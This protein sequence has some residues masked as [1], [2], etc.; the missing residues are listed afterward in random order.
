MCA[1]I[2]MARTKK[3]HNINTEDAEDTFLDYFPD[4]PIRFNIIQRY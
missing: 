2:I 4:L 1:Y 3:V